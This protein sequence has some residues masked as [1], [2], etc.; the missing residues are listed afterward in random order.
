MK[1]IILIF[2]W[3]LC[4]NAT[5]QI[6]EMPKSMLSP[7][8]ASL[9]EYGEVPVSPF[10]GI[11]QIEIP[12][13]QVKS[14]HHALPVSISYHAGGVRPDQI[15]GVLGTGWSLNAGG[16]ISRVVKGAIDE[17]HNKI[18]E[19]MINNSPYNINDALAGYFFRHNY[20][21]NENWNTFQNIGTDI[22]QNEVY[23]WDLEPDE[24]SFNFLD[25]H[26]KFFLSSDGQWKVRCDRPVKIIFDSTFVDNPYSTIGWVYG[27]S[28]VV[29]AIGNKGYSQAF[30]KFIIIGEDGTQYTFGDQDN[31]IEYSLNFWDTIDGRMVATSWY[32][33]K[34]KYT[35]GREINLQYERDGFV[36]QLGLSTSYDMKVNCVVNGYMTEVTESGVINPDTINQYNGCLTVP[37]Y[38]LEI[39]GEDTGIKLFNT[40]AWDMAY[41]FDWLIRRRISEPENLPAAQLAYK[42]QLFANEQYLISDIDNKEK[43]HFDN[44]M[45]KKIGA[46]EYSSYRNG[47]KINGIKTWEFIYNHNNDSYDPQKDLY[48]GIDTVRTR[49]FLDT[50]KCLS[51]DRTQQD[52]IYSFHYYKRD[53]LPVYLTRETDHWGFYNG[54]VTDYINISNFFQS[55]N[56]NINT[57]YSLIGTLD[58]IDYPTGGYT[59][60]EFEPHRVSKVA[61][62]N[63]IGCSDTTNNTLAGGLRIRKI[64]SAPSASEDSVVREFSYFNDYNPTTGLGTVSS[65]ILGLRPQYLFDNSTSIYSYSGNLEYSYYVQTFS[66]QNI[67]PCTENSCGTHVGY[68]NVAERFS[69]GSCNIYHYTNY[70]D[71][72]GD[73]P[74]DNSWGGQFYEPY[75]ERPMER[76]QLKSIDCYAM[77]GNSSRLTKRTVT[78]F[79]KDDSN[80]NSNYVRA[81]RLKRKSYQINT[82]D[83]PVELPYY[84]CTAYRDYTYLMRPVTVNDTLIEQSINHPWT[85]STS[86]SYNDN[87]LVSDI[88]TTI[89]S[90]YVKGCSYTYPD[91]SWYPHLLNRH[92]L[93]SPVK[94]VEYVL[95]SDNNRSNVLKTKF[96]YSNGSF[97]PTSIETAKGNAA[98]ESRK[99][100]EYDCYGN[101]IHEITDSIQHTVFLWGYN[102][103]YPVAVIENATIAEVQG[104][105]GDIDT[106]ASSETPSFNKLELLRSNLPDAQVTTYTYK[107]G[108][109]VESMTKP[110][111]SSLFYEYDPLGRLSCVKDTDGNVVEAYKY[112]FTHYN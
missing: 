90:G 96:H 41:N 27:T 46:I 50:L 78:T 86:Y 93:S 44:I 31:A 34:I 29:S 94:K 60:F 62:I 2:L 61:N 105:V 15:P 66:S 73:S 83:Y 88:Q 102:G 71:G 103:M 40:T 52:G 92:I 32:L 24:F 74:C 21:N 47:T 14:G 72:H 45:H 101:V 97:F 100:Y 22:A 5:A 42:L 67:M 6:P 18:V 9:G 99:S 98:Y 10:T 54:R 59:R 48:L 7:S 49:L 11:P 79:D 108:V 87:K 80:E 53:E 1:K 17:Y 30:R 35:D 33:T 64:I 95:Y 104:I 69:D 28:S 84:E 91:A 63:H 65:G 23:K 8:A 25:Y 37:C 38:L 82:M 68:S 36:A 76:G 89:N 107:A 111:G 26:G 39:I 77:S 112:N 58:R 3:L 70:D 57:E 110:N 109:G 85:Q 12:L 19:G 4:L 13:C 43:I 51:G 106:F 75:N 55:K 56:P 16:C 20:L 81:I